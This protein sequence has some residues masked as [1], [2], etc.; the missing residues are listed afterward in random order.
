MARAR[1]AVSKPTKSVLMAS[2]QAC[3][4]NGERILDDAV[5]VEFQDPPCIRLMLSMIAQEEFA[6]AFLLFLV[7]EDVVPWSAQLLRAMNDHACKHLV[8]VII[9]Y[10]EPEWETIDDL[11][12]MT[13]EELERGERLPPTVASAINIL[14]HEKI[15]RWEAGNWVWAEPPDYEPSIL[16]IANGRRDRIKQDALYVRLGRDGSVASTP[17]R[18]SLASADDEYSKAHRY[19]LFVDS[20]VRDGER[21]SIAYGKVHGVLKVI[22]QK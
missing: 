21:R 22:F 6:K 11:K 16:R 5:Y 17:S 4:T 8:G 14:R 3:I 2:M 15:G 12:R 10:L 19:R 1:A 9:E 20:L 18:V 7:C 13:T